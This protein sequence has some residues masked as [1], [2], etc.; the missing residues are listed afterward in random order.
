MAKGAA[1]W[2]VET[3]PEVWLDDHGAIHSRETI[4]QRV[5]HMAMDALTAAQIGVKVG[6]LLEELERREA[7]KARVA[8][9]IGTEAEAGEGGDGPPPLT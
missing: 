4:G 8:Q 2:W 9:G 1:I 5:F 6:T 7:L 3:V